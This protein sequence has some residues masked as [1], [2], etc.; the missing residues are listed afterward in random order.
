MRTLKLM[1]DYECWPLW[2]EGE[3]LDPATLPLSKT[4]QGRLLAWATVF[5]GSL[6]WD[7][8]GHSP[9]MAP[10]VKAAFLEEGRRLAEDLAEELGAGW[11][12]L[13]WPELETDPRSGG[14]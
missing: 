12:I 3:N 8:P 5:D 14:I 13:S 7:D 10:E 11:R 2:E 9:P 6:D 1:P 4:L